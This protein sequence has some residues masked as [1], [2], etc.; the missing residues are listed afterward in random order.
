[1]TATKTSRTP[2]SLAALLAACLS[3]LYPP[4]WHV[5]L[6][7]AC[8]GFFTHWL[9]G[10]FDYLGKRVLLRRPLTVVGANN[11]RIGDASTIGKGSTLSVW[12]TA[13]L[14]VKGLEIGHDTHIGEYAHITCANNIVIGNHVLTGR[15]L[16][17]TD[18]AHGNLSPD[19]LNLPPI[20]RTLSSKG[21]VVIGNKVWIGD[22]VTILPGVTI[23]DQA[24]IGANAV[25]TADVPSKAMVGGNP[26]RL[27]KQLS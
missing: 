25:V 21:P 6:S 13:G 18:N 14:R 10:Q 12:K 22:K 2:K 15:W 17:I 7:L 3:H 27:I 4:R 9:S 5:A 11:I 1:M 24:I 23:G 19:M 8:D 26:A 16:T 20:L